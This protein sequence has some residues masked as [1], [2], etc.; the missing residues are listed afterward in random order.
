M[1]KSLSEGSKF[2]ADMSL[3]AVLQYTQTKSLNYHLLVETH[4]AGYI[5]VGFLAKVTHLSLQ[6]FQYQL[7]FVSTRMTF[8]NVNLKFA[9]KLLLLYY[10]IN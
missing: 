2:G 6:N 4:I 5:Q 9:V 8:V 10:K 3:L 1:K 7:N